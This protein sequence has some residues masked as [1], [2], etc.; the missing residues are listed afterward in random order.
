MDFAI[1]INK[2]PI[3]MTDERW[4]HITIGHPE[5]AVYYDE[6]LEAIEHPEFVYLGSNEEY[7]AIRKLNNDTSKFIVVIYK[8]VNENDGFIIT[9][10]VTNKKPYF[11]KK[12]MIWKQ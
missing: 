9:S 11:T 2:V 7:L 12:K 10:F 1:S 8:E 3:R 6:I 4:Y 5:I